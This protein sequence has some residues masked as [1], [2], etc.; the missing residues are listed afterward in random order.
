MVWYGDVP[1][2]QWAV[3]ELLV[4]GKET[5]TNIQ[6]RLKI[7]TVSVL[8]IKALLV[9]GLHQLQV[10]RKARWTSV[11]PITLVCHQQ[12][13]LRRCFSVLMNAFEMTDRLQSESLQLSYQ[14]SR[15]V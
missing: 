1:F 5:V 10:P 7:C 3:T 11:M 14:Y 13:S 4:A 6:K 9:F 12:L 15:K 8:F 2:K